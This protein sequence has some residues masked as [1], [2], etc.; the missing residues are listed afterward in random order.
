MC[1]IL[2]AEDNPALAHVLK[3]NLKRAGHEVAVHG[4]GETAWAAIQGEAFDLIL[5]DHQMPKMTGVTLCRK[6]RESHKHSSI[7]IILLT[8]KSLE[9][10][11][12][13]LRERLQIYR[14]FPKPYSPSAIVDTVEEAFAAVLQ[15]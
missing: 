8:G 3:L 11:Q 14:V 5:T 10:N 13:E 9:L 1:K 6:V 15:Y 7:P 2:V 4:N 12:D